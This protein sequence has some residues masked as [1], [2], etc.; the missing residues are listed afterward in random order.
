M[1]KPKLS[2]KLNQETKLPKRVIDDAP[3]QGPF[4]DYA[5]Y[6]LGIY[7]VQVSLADSIEFLR[8]YGAWEDSELQD[9]ETNK[10]RILWLACLDCKERETRYFY[11]G[12]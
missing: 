11:M 1:S 6:L 3:M 10:A 2:F 4:D 7:D 9:L 8:R 5:E 12:E